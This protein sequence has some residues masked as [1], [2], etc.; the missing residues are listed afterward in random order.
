MRLSNSLT[1]LAE[2]DKIQ[3]ILIFN[4]RWV[5]SDATPIYHHLTYKS[6]IA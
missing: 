4:T 2:I 3:T 1:V 5:I 6:V